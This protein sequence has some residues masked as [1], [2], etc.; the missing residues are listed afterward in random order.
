[1]STYF[2]K[3]VTQSG[4]L[5]AIFPVI[6]TAALTL[7]FA[8]TWDRSWHQPGRFCSLVILNES[9][10]GW[11]GLGRMNSGRII[12]MPNIITI[13]VTIEPTYTIFILYHSILPMAFPVRLVLPNE[14]YT[15][16][17]PFLQ[18]QSD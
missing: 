16:C 9:S 7:F 14:T 11:V 4:C 2:G 10:M 1:M 17:R 15:A 5:S 13:P 18:H 12:A 3:L 6:N 8:S